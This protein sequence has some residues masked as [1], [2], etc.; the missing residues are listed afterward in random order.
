MLAGMSTQPY[1]STSQSWSGSSSS[2]TSAEDA[3]NDLNDSTLTDGTPPSDDSGSA[4]ASA[5]PA[6]KSKP[7]KRAA[8]GSPA[9]M[10]AKKMAARK[11]VAT[12]VSL[13]EL[14]GDDLAL[15]GSLSGLPADDLESLAVELSTGSAA[16]TSAA[17]TLVE[18]ADRS[19]MEAMVEATILADNDP[20]AY[21]GLFALA[22][23]LGLDVPA[24]PRGPS[25]RSSMNLVQSLSGLD[26]DVRA[27]L[28]RGVQLLS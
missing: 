17:T 11:A 8:G 18:L 13:A 6:K 3:G 9:D 27:R 10:R 21:R 4:S 1:D 5:A 25:V 15:V 22:S 24:T 14:D 20:A 23:T 28:E 7:S 2:D 26:P 12:Y 16:S 19:D